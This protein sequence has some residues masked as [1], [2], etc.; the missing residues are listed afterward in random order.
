MKQVTRFVSGGLFAGCLALGLMSGLTLTAISAMA[1]GDTAAPAPPAVR[2][3]GAGTLEDRVTVFSRSLSLDAGQQASLRRILIEQR[4]AVR[5]IWSDRALLPA[6]R[7]PATRAANE[8]TG[9][10]I[11]AMLND[12]QKK[13]YNPP[14][15]STP[16]EAGDKRS[17]EQWLDATRSKQE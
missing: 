10:Q 12:E 6:E 15:P 2:Q 8:R 16:H 11:R 17:V 9:D 14:K 13:K 7:A 1:A 3:L 4:D 5:R